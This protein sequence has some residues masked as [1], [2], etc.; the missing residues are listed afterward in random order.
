MSTAIAV[1]SRQ[2][3]AARTLLG[4]GV[5]NAMEWYDWNVYASFAAFFSGQIFNGADQAS[6]FMATMGV[7]AVG[8]IARP[9]GGA[10]FG[11]IADRVGRKYSMMLTVG[12]ASAG[13]LVIALDPTY[14]QIGWVSSLIL[15]V[16]RLVQGL[17]HG[18][19]LPSAQTYLSEEAPKERRGLWSSSI[20]ISGTVGMLFGML[21]GL[22][23]N[24][25]LTKAQM[26]AFGWRIPFLVGAV[27]GVFSLWMRSRMG[28]S[29]IFEEDVVEDAGPKENVFVGVLRNWRTALQIIFVTGG[30]TISY[31]VWSV[32]MA[33][34]AQTSFGFSAQQAFVATI[35]GTVVLILSLAPWG[36]FS[37]HFGR[38]TNLWISMFGCALLYVPIRNMI[39]D[40]T[41][42]LILGISIMLF[43]MAANLAVAPAV[44]AEMFPTGSRATGMAIPYAIAIAVFGG[45][46]PLL[47]TAWKS[48]AGWFETYNIGMLV[49]AG[50]VVFTLKETKGIDL[51]NK[52]RADDADPRRSGLVP[53][54][55]K[56]E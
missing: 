36:L 42:Q 2:Q 9:F 3:G 35:I 21:L 7:F 31:Y 25:V 46:A 13:S 8:F 19:E 52:H 27:F 14:H 11:W 15:V 17:A 49:V 1:E 32:A 33:S 45:T 20:Y 56:A 44:Y 41:W 4:T 22:F 24:S 16:A 51:S 47:M 5:G 54:A 55:G 53:G 40:Q 29:E 34:L 50:L 6:A 30:L 23:L 37:D 39:H 48:H 38:R 10:V 43:L 28:E 12:C 26:G 18:G